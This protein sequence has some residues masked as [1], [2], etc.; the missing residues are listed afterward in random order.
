MESLLALLLGLRHRQVVTLRRIRVVAI[1]I[2]LSGASFALFSYFW[3][4]PF[5]PSIGAASILTAVII[6]IFCYTTIY[7][8]LR[9][10]QAQIRDHVH[11]RQPTRG[12]RIPLNIAPFKKT[13]SSI[14]W[15]QLALVVCYV[16]FGV[17]AI[18][19]NI[20]GWSRISRLLWVFAASLV[21]LNS[22]LNPI[23]YF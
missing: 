11:Q 6:S 2:W 5:S 23:L 17:V 7:V 15:V 13:V 4:D 9:Q 8:R 3:N 14:A 18:I 19:V 20:S 16:P 10:N 12:E 1:S 21:N 22:S